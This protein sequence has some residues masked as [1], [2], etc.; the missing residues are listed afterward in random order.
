PRSLPYLRWRYGEAPGLGYRAVVEGDPERPDG[1]AIFRV[2]PRGSLWEAA[3]AEALVR[4]GD[5][6]TAARLLRRVVRAVRADHLTC[7]FP[8]GS[9]ALGAAR[10][11][12][13]LPAPAGITLVALPLADELREVARDLGRWALTLGDLEVF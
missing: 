12:G 3:V 1:L 10:R 9:T 4:P 11:A 13:F 5:R 7:S 8:P 6:A 2:R